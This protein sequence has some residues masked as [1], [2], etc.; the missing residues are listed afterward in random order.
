MHLV[1]DVYILHC[2]D[3]YCWAILLQWWCCLW[4]PAVMHFNESRLAEPVSVPGRS[5]QLQTVFRS[6]PWCCRWL[7]SRVLQ[8]RRAGG[9]WSQ[10]FCFT[11]T[12]RLVSLILCLQSD[13]MEWQLHGSNLCFPLIRGTLFIKTVWFNMRSM[14]FC[15]KVSL[16]HQLIYTVN[17]LRR[18][19]GLSC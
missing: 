12:M 15:R 14:L 7:K 3:Y 13:F 2:T 16:T 19:L 17:S 6:S 10:Q 8:D 11:P 1:N 9:Q 5:A 18:L 4:Q